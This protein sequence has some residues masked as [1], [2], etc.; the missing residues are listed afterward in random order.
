MII[1]KAEIKDISNV[2]KIYEKLNTDKRTHYSNSEY[3]ESLIN[4]GEMFIASEN[5]EPIAAIEFKIDD[6][7]KNCEI[8]RVASIKR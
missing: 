5:G 6:E 2:A 3:I 8:I 4:K 1:K 7:D